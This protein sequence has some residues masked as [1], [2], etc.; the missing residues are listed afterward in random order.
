MQNSVMDL[1][2]AVSRATEENID[3]IEGVM[4]QTKLLAIN[5]RVEAARA[6]A[7]GNAF[8]VVAQEMGG[9]A[10]E[11]TRIS[12]VLRSS[13]RTNTEKLEVVGS[14]LNLKFR[15][16]RFTDLALNA[17]EIIDRN[18]YER[19]CDV[20]WWATDSA[21]VDAARS[22]SAESCNYA[23]QRLA[24]ILRAYTVY[25][26]LWVADAQGRVIAHGRGSKYRSI[27]GRDVSSCDWFREAMQTRSGDDFVACNIADNPALENAQVAT[28]ATAIREGGA[29]NGRRIGA[30]GIFFDW[31]PQAS[32]I[33]SNIALSDDEKSRTHVML[34]DQTGRVI[35]S[36]AQDRLGS[37]FQIKTDGKTSGFYLHNDR[38]IAFALTPGYETYKGLGWYGVID[39]PAE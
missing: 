13:I 37:N 7:S 12:K 36:R 10:E 25:L 20:R 1:A 30:L 28:Y 19:S 18:L 32:A 4:R 35:A 14:E 21:V 38:L 33:V 24:T 29:V 27:I 15:G 5:A 11:I 34:V 31:A 22:S 6:G 9:V 26:D 2:F 8:A 23:N 39:A 17:I 3:L 16:T